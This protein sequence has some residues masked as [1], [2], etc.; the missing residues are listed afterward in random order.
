[1]T[2]QFLAVRGKIEREGL[3]IHVVAEELID[4]T[5]E[6]QPPRRRHRRHAKPHQ[7]APRRLLDAQEP[8]LSLIIA[9]LVLRT[10][11]SGC[12]PRIKP[13]LQLRERR[14]IRQLRKRDS[15]Y[16]D[17]FGKTSNIIVV[18]IDRCATGDLGNRHNLAVE[19][20]FL[21]SAVR[22]AST[23][24]AHRDCIT[25]H[26]RGLNS[27]LRSKRLDTE[28][29]RSAYDIE[30]GR[31]SVFGAHQQLAERGRRHNDP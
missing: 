10:A 6:L 15:R 12:L 23:L 4:L 29:A 25:C 14:W 27:S 28:K 5:D 8:G 19:F 7:G 1:M 30:I 21:P 26:V 9:T 11:L 24:I 13:H 22:G 18:R 31:S 16:R 20:H 2:A 3:V 17:L